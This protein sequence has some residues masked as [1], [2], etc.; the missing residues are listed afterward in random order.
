MGLLNFLTGWAVGGDYVQDM[1]EGFGYAV[2]PNE[3]KYF[4]LEIHYENP[5][6]SRD[7]SI[8]SKLRLWTTKNLRAVEFGILTVGTDVAP[9]NILLPPKMNRISLEYTCRNDFFNVRLN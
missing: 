3:F 5:T 6:M 4:F 9:V 8:N 2:G 1:P 7:V